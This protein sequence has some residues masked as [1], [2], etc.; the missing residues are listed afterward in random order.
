M[1]KE[2]AEDFARNRNISIFS[3]T[4]A[5]N[6]VNVTSLF[7]QIGENFLYDVKNRAR[8]TRRKGTV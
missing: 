6:D 3:L 1:S 7:Y 5:K 4:S 2:R 8:S